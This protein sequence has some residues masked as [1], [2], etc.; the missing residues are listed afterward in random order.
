MAIYNN[1]HGKTRGLKPREKIDMSQY[2]TV[3]RREDRTEHSVREQEGLHVRPDTVGGGW[4]TLVAR[5]P[6]SVS[7]S[8]KIGNLI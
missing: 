3:T 7:N 5:I 8:P 1:Q 2:I 6:R 4:K